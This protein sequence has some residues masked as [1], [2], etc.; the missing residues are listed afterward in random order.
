[1]GEAALQVLPKKFLGQ[2]AG[3]VRASPGPASV[4]WALPRRES[5]PFPP[6]ELLSPTPR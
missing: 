2:G 5:L 6:N 3:M 4:T 1:M